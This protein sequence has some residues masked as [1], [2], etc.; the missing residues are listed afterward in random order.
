MDA[1]YLGDFFDRLPAIIAQARRRMHDT[2]FEVIERIH[3]RLRDTLYLL[4]CGFP[5]MRTD[6]MISNLLS[7]RCNHSTKLNIH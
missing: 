7:Q 3:R 6:K 1:A 4:C 2:E 5:L